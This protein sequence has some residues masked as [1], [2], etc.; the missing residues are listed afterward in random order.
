MG[1]QECLCVEP[2]RESPGLALLWNSDTQI[3][4]R[5]CSAH[6]IDV[7]VGKDGM[8]PWRFIGIY[9]FA[10]REVRNRTWDLIEALAL[11]QC[12]LAWLMAGDFNEIMHSRDKSGGP[13]RS[14]AAMAKF[15]S[16]MTRCQLFDIGFV[17]SRFI[18]SNKFTKERLDISFQS[19]LWRIRFP[20]SRAVTLHPSDSDHNPILVEVKS[21]RDTS[22]RTCKRFRYEE[23]WFGRKEPEDI[24]KQAWAKPTTGN[25]MGQIAHKIKYAGYHLMEWHRSDREKQRRETRIIEEKLNDLM[26][27]PYSSQQYKE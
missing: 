20:Y 19:M 3:R 22:Y 23:G 27:Q 1:F 15:R 8:D 21:E 24:I 13:P 11:Q 7:E 4:L 25:I 5:T 12:N 6:H 10:G 18:W 14:G 17:G 9:G 2:G 26:R 16:T